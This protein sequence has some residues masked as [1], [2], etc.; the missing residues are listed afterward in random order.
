MTTLLAL[1]LS[2]VA[3]AAPL[4]GVR[5]R[6]IPQ[7]QAKEVIAKSRGAR[8]GC[9]AGAAEV[10]P[11]PFRALVEADGSVS[12]VSVQGRVPQAARSCIQAKV[13]ALRFPAP[14]GG[15]GMVA[16]RGRQVSGSKRSIGGATNQPPPCRVSRWAFAT[17]TPEHCAAAVIEP[18][19]SLYPRIR[20]CYTGTFAGALPVQIDLRAGEVT[21]VAVP[22]DGLTKA[23]RACVEDVGRSLSAPGVT[24][25]FEVDYLMPQHGG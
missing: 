10:E 16:F 7:P 14:A 3:A 25:R 12:H 6:A 11:V 13:E 17:A 1:A 18:L 20:G 2:T 5:A 23:Q 21:R 9:V 4:K 15:L 19:W 8:D 24:G 22:W